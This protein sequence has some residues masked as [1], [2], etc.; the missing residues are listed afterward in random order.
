MQMKTNKLIKKLIKKLQK[1]IQKMDLV[2][3]LNFTFVLAYVIQRLLA[4]F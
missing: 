3:D 4:F 2:E 1:N